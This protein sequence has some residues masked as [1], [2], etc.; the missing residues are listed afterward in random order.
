MDLILPPLKNFILPSGGFAASSLHL[1]NFYSFFLSSI[2]RT[3][4]R[5]SERNLI[6]LYKE[7]Q[8]E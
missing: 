1:G 2:A 6:H 7:E 4:C 5:R 3:V 8:I